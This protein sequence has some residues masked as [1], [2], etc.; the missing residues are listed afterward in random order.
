MALIQENARIE[1]SLTMTIS[2][3]EARA[4]DAL[5][6]YGTDEFIRV[7]YEKLGKA[8]M[9]PHEAGLREFFKTTRLS[10][11]SAF[12][13]FDDARSVFNGDKIASTAIKTVRAG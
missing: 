12:K 9:E 10:L 7:F 8:Y 1:F 11:G 4:L 13:R 3:S 6:G 2:E 5:V